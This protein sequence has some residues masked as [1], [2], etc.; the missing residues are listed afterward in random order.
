MPIVANQAGVNDRRGGRRPSSPRPLRPA[1]R[2]F[3]GRLLGD[4]QDRRSVLIAVLVGLLT[5]ATG[6][7][8]GYYVRTV[9]RSSSPEAT[10]NGNLVATAVDARSKRINTYWREGINTFH[11]YYTDRPNG[12][13]IDGGRFTAEQLLERGV[14]IP[15]QVYENDKGAASAPQESNAL[16]IRLKAL[17][18]HLN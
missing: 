9:S 1:P 2:G 3:W 11:Y 13:M 14:A 5:G 8:T 12:R 7:G 4:H 18:D 6:L 10:E 16:A 17:R 15:G